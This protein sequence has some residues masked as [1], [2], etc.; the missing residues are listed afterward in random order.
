MPPFLLSEKY[1]FEIVCIF[2]IRL[3]ICKR[4]QNL[5][6]MEKVFMSVSFGK[7]K[8]TRFTEIE[9]AIA[10]VRE[11]KLSNTRLKL[12]KV[13]SIEDWDNF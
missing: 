3:Y 7:F 13:G 5:I 9:E 10:F 2:K 12:T 6:K 11:K 4:N 1:F 8:R